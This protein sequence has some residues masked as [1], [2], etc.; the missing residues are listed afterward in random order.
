MSASMY[1]HHH[2]NPMRFMPCHPIAHRQKPYYTSPCYIN[3]VY[4]I[5]V[6]ILQLNRLPTREVDGRRRQQ[7]E[8]CELIPSPKGKDKL[9]VH[10][11]LFLQNQSRKNKFY[12]RCDQPSKPK[13]AKILSTLKQKARTSR[14]KPAKI[15]Q[16]IYTSMDINNAQSSK[17]AMRQ[18]I[19]R[20]RRQNVM[21]EPTPLDSLFIP[22]ELK[23]TSNGELYL[24]NEYEIGN[25]KILLFTT[26]VNLLRAP[27][28][29]DTNSQILSLDFALLSSKSKQ[30]YV[31][32]FQ[33]LQAYASENNIVL[34][35]DYI[36]TDFKQAAIWGVKQEFTTSQI[37]ISLSFGKKYMAK[38]SVQ[39][40]PSA[41]SEIK[42]QLEIES[43][44]EHL[45][46][47][48][49]NNYVL[50]RVRKTQRNGNLIRVLPLFS[51]ELWS[52]FNQNIPRTQNNIEAWYQ[53][54]ESILVI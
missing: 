22:D 37:R 19:K 17:D 46:M 47:W 51:P 18:Q 23:H 48:F 30:Y 45:I 36:L 41:F 50:G 52:V 14:D 39:E 44:T 3:G 13:I 11:Y 35:P 12:L 49:E 42:E 6:V 32:V 43:G 29:H 53:R 21:S 40:I 38:S 9:N 33:D 15:I 54:W 5:S 27:I 24:I 25:D 1:L 31:C 2:S 8:I 7:M 28:G 34:R 10:G 20:V 16:S 26:L 4:K